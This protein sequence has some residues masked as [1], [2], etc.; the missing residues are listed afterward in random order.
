MAVAYL[1]ATLGWRS[2]F[3]IFALPGILWAVWFLY[4]FRD[5]PQDHPGVNAGE[6]VLIRGSATADAAP[7]S[8]N[9]DARVPWR[10]LLLSP[11]LCWICTQQF[12]RGAGYIFYSSWFTTYLRESCGVEIKAAGWLTSLQRGRSLRD[13]RPIADRFDILL[14]EPG[15]VMDECVRAERH[16]PVGN[17]ITNFHALVR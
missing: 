15:L 13:G 6:L 17:R 10:A 12:F 7:L 1:A 8:E 9:G 11:A 14:G 2:P 4:W 3:V 16:A 5:R